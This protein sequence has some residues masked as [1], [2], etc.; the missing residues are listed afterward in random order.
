MLSL[1]PALSQAGDEIVIVR[2]SCYPALFRVFCKGE[3]R[4]DTENDIDNII[5]HFS[6]P[7][8]LNVHVPQVDTEAYDEIDRLPAH[9]TKDF[10]VIWDT[11]KS[12][13]KIDT[14]ILREYILMSIS[15]QTME[16]NI[17]VQKPEPPPPA[18]EAVPAAAPAVTP[19]TGGEEM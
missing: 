1:F 9:G 12:F 14:D 8:Y 10:V 2:K 7:S 6:S 5:I 19:P 13:D 11:S 16:I 3:V 4:N 17:V 18:P 15:N